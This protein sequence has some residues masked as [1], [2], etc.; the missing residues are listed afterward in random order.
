MLN[1]QGFN[2]RRSTAVIAQWLVALFFLQGLMPLQAHSRIDTDRHG[3][4]I[5]ICTL[6]GDKTLLVDFDDRAHNNVPASSAMLFS[7]LLNDLSPVLPATQPPA[8]VLGRVLLP[9]QMVAHVA[10]RACVDASSR[11]PPRA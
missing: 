3:T 11:A 8:L 1:L 5:V 9:Q 7:D 2:H 10:T 6:E 4:P